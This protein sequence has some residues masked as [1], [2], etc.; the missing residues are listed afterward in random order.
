MTLITKIKSNNFVMYENYNYLEYF[1]ST[2]DFFN[3]F[4]PYIN[5][6]TELVL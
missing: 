2:P 1:I 4:N 6:D 3:H 5:C